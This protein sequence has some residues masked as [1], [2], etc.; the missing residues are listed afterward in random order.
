MTY[1][2]K[3][4]V[5]QNKQIEREIQFLSMNALLFDFSTQ[6]E[7]KTELRCNFNKPQNIESTATIY[8]K[9][10]QIIRLIDT[11]LRLFDLT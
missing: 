7:I 11:V 1:F 6:G 10:N 3:I 9:N 8:Q 2:V 5:R 4:S